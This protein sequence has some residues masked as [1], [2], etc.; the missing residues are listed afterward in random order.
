[1]ATTFSNKVEILSNLWSNYK[2]DE[3]FQDFVEYNDVGLPLA[4]MYQ[5]RLCDLTADGEN[6]IEETWTLFIQALGVEDV[7][8]E[9]INEV[10]ASAE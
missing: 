4:Y 9:N 3:Q 7:G 10:F 1:M 6:Y 8:F 5:E 2:S